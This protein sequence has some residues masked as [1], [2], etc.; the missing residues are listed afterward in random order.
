MTC[1]N[2][3]A[4]ASGKFCSNCG[5]ALG[6][7]TCPQ[8]GVSLNAGAKFCHACGAPA[9]GAGPG[10]AHTAG[11][12][13]GTPWFIA[14]GAVV[15]VLL[16]L[17]VTQLRPPAPAAS[18]PAAAPA[19]GPVDLSQ[20][21]P[22]QAA[23]RLFDRV[24]SDRE[25]GQL[26]SASFFAPMALRAYG[27]LDSLDPLARFDIGLLQ[28]VAGDPASADSQADTIAQAVPTH[29]YASMLHAE[30]AAARGDVAAAKRAGAVYL[31]DYDAEM[32]A[33]RPE[34][35]SHAPWLKSYRD[36]IAGK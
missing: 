2:C 10:R 23:E 7:R 33:G 5:A 32:A 20:M 22:R 1:P 26:D 19:S 25:R 30:A 21:T 14:G 17:A 16:I 18:A 13:S 36:S 35:E 11:M 24:M 6:A 34:Y 12:P 8:C 9:A 4:T 31:R 15:V 28:I 29:L 27:M 3:G